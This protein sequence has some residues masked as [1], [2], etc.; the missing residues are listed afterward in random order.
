[1]SSE[2]TP[3]QPAAEA[4]AT[5][6]PTPAAAPEA[7][8]PERPRPEGSRPE[9]SRY[10]GP[11]TGPPSGGRRPSPGG[12]GARGLGGRRPRRK[13]CSFCMEKSPPI[14]YKDVP[15]MRRFVSERGKILPRRTTGTCASHQRA[16]ARAVKR[17]REIALLPFVTD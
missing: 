13:V 14:T 1:M 10:D 3:Q 11:R 9:G 6:E 8:R 16:L 17:A 12:P 15:K 5:P 4:P 2:E 7:P